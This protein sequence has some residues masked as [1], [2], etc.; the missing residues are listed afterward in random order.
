MF[1]HDSICP[2]EALIELTMYI[3]ST[4]D[5]PRTLGGR[6][7]TTTVHYL[8]MLLQNNPDR[9]NILEEVLDQLVSDLTKR[10]PVLDTCLNA[11]SIAMAHMAPVPDYMAKK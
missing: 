11:L 3:M 9:M 7:V 4:G 2:N 6:Q 10:L 1:S 5:L 8:S